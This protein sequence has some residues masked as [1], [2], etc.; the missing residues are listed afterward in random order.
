MIKIQKN[1]LNIIFKE[2]LAKNFLGIT[3]DIE[4]APSQ[5]QNS[6]PANYE[7]Y[8]TT[9]KREKHREIQSSRVVIRAVRKFMK[10]SN[11]NNQNLVK[12]KATKVIS[13]DVDINSDENTAY[14]MS[15]NKVRV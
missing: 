13:H 4:T 1:F 2:K 15:I 12:S 7:P 9:L 10:T 14:L 8:T 6:N 3:K 11:L 5:I